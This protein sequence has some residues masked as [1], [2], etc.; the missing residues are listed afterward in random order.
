[1]ASPIEKHLVRNFA[2]ISQASTFDDA[3]QQLAER[4]QHYIVMV[5][6]DKKIQALL[7]KKNLATSQK[8]KKAL[9]SL[10]HSPL[11]TLPETEALDIVDI[12][13][14]FHRDIAKH[15]DILGIVLL[16]QH[17]NAA[18][19]LEREV[20]ETSFSPDL[21][22]S[23]AKELFQ[24]Q[25]YTGMRGEKAFGIGDGLRGGNIP[26]SASS[27]VTDRNL[28]VTRY[29]NLQ[30]PAQVSLNQHC[31]L[32]ITV[33]RHPDAAARQEVELGLTR[34][35]WPLRLVVNLVSVKPEDFLIKGL[36]Y[37]LIEVPRMKDSEPLTFTLIPQSLGEKDIAIQ[38]EQM[39]D[40]G[41]DY[42]ITTNLRTEVIATPVAPGDHAEVR[43]APTLTS[44]C[45]PPD[46]TIYIKHMHDLHYTIYA[47]TAKNTQQAE[48]PLI[49][50]IDFPQTPVAY[51]RTLFADLDRK[52]SGGLSR[53]EYD[54]EVRRIGNKLYKELFHEEGFKRFYW[55]TLDALP[56]EAT[57]QII[58]DE[59]YIPWEILR[60]YSEKPDGSLVSDARYFCE[61]FAFS[62][63]FT[64]GMQPVNQLP[65][66]KVVV[67][68][69]PTNL[70]WVEEE[71]EAIK[72]IPGLQVDVLRTMPKLEHFLT[73]GEAD[74]VHFACHGA[75]QENYPGR[76]VL[77]I[78]NR[79]LQP[80]DLVAEDCYFGRVHPLVFLNACESGQQGI[81][82]TGLD[83]WAKAFL[84]AG[85]GF[86]IGSV[87]KTTD[88]LA[89][90]FA[91]TFYT[92]L[93]KGDSVSEAMRHAR[94]A[95][96]RSGDAT[97]LSY[98]LYAHPR[99]RARSQS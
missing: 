65:L 81:G 72:E 38:F 12:A 7:H 57:V 86:F 71:V 34:S 4:G 58:S 73:K 21:S 48:L 32:T 31:E 55:T 47:R 14:F 79:Y 85:V 8:N 70:Q 36:S 3:H 84:D 19:I 90:H 45:N 66:L 52:T 10:P 89:Y 2:V 75:F 37:G 62:R 13:A 82:L 54:T 74:V 67:V 5:D 23:H 40:T 25:G 59:P 92:H 39:G 49:D 33:N 98:T 51:M 28:H 42:I 35:E 29:G 61:R 11:L 41:L 96:V 83:G 17:N 15:P 1:M 93:L 22:R 27:A 9:L 53:E 80:D 46:V 94:K 76:S 88:V 60:P 50:E 87:W 6:E 68:A 69:P 26:S 99:A 30:F 78:G 91:H 16:D 63:W 43:H 95:T 56:D 18:A 97:Y 20:I 64:K 24:A 44:A 77:Q